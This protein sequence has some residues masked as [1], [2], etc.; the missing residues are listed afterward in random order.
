[1]RTPS[2]VF[3]ALAAATIAA[4]CL[5]NTMGLP[6]SSTSD[7]GM[8]PGTGGDGTSATTSSA[9]STSATASSGSGVDAGSDVDT[10]DACDGTELGPEEAQAFPSGTAKK[11]D[12]KTDD[13]GCEPPLLLDATT[14]K[15]KSGPDGGVFAVSAQVRI[16][17]D[18]TALYFL[19]EITDPTVDGDD[20][21]A[22]WKN[23]SIELYLG[24]SPV[25][26]GNYGALD[27][28]YIID[29][30]GLSQESSPPSPPSSTPAHLHYSVKVN[31]GGYVVE[32]RVDA[33]ALGAPLLAGKK[34]GFDLL[35]NDGINEAFYLIWALSSHGDCG[36]C[37]GGCCCSTGG[38]WDFPSCDR[39]RFGGLTLRP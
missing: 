8:G 27:H 10:P 25:P 38:K 33:V 21:N 6:G 5:L 24:G 35:L 3:M 1:M 28:H 16:E 20:P 37:T 34:L 26:T 23:D 7:G 30:K 29:H 31:P 19:A 2:L 18:A 36:A 22:P 17:W 9:G 13:W 15:L 39:L 4:G 32:A 12:G 11:I 14:A